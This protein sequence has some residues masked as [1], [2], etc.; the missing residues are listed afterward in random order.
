MPEEAF[1]LI[2][3][4]TFVAPSASRR[5]L[6][7]MGSCVPSFFSSQRRRGLDTAGAGQVARRDLHFICWVADVSVLYVAIRRVSS[8]MIAAH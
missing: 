7:R 6:A 3:P 1:F 2:K 8:A 5:E 4:L